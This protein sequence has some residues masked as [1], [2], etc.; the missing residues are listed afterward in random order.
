[1][2]AR[3]EALF[4]WHLTKT[5]RK[6]PEIEGHLSGN[7]HLALSGCKV[8][9]CFL[10]ACIQLSSL[11]CLNID[12]NLTDAHAAVTSQTNTNTSHVEAIDVFN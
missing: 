10:I 2:S 5:N 7:R 3:E 11:D 12:Y 1:M 4:K 9:K 6:C 8:C